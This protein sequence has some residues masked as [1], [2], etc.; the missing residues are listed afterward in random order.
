ML[1][2]WPLLILIL[3]S[4]SAIVL[5]TSRLK[6]H[7]FLALI[8]ASLGVGLG[9]GISPTDLVA[10]MNQGFGSLMSY[11]GVVVVLGSI[12]GV[13][14][15]RSGAT[16][17]L[18][19]FI[20]R[21]SGPKRPVLGLTLVGA[22]VGIPVFCDSG[23]VI[24]S[25]LNKGIAQRTGVSRASLTLGLAGGLYTTHTLVPPTPGPIA[26]AG[27]LGL[28]DQLGYVILLGLLVAIPVG[29]VVLKMAQ[30]RGAKL[31]LDLPELKESSFEG[32]LPKL[33][34]AILPIFL[35]L[36]LITLGTCG[37]L[38]GWEGT[39]GNLIT[40][41]GNPVLALLIGT[42]SALFLLPNWSN[43][44]AWVKAGIMAAGPILILTGAGGIFGAVLKATPVKE[45]MEGWLSSG[46]FAQTGFLMVAWLIA[47]FLKSAQGSSTSA[48]IITAS[49]LAPLTAGAGLESP[50]GLALLTLSIG[51]GAMTV[52]HAN[53]SFFWVVS[54]FGEL[55][56]KQAYQSYTLMTLAQGLMVLTMV[57]LLSLGLS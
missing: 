25:Q 21:I 50:Y 29:W 12:I 17:R 9:T 2:G 4:V 37:Q 5:A 18:A 35:P 15:E 27:T 56:M 34:L 36:L 19:E 54:Q 48:L 7:P 52:S 55:P 33:W 8:L 38:L 53:D 22:L 23:F 32:D 57:L 1:T 14:L 11:I 20:L 43:G 39:L 28:S 49:M 47:A 16:H 10:V 44:E 13:I 31:E 46:A 3:A 41:L 42:A 45:V 6:L 24:L 40:F 30:W 26:A 51:G